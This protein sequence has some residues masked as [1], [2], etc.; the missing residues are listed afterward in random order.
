ME[1]VFHQRI[2]GTSKRLED[3][4]CYCKKNYLQETE[5]P[6]MEIEYTDGRTGETKTQIVPKTS[7][8]EAI[9]HDFSSLDFENDRELAEDSINALSYFASNGIEND[10]FI[11]IKPSKATK[12]S[13]QNCKEVW[14]L[15][16]FLVRV[17]ICH[18]GGAGHVGKVC[19]HAVEIQNKRKSLMISAC[20][21]LGWIVGLE[22]TTFR[23]TI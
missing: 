19:L 1:E 11:N 16:V 20:F 6:T 13:F 9:G 2:V 22:P 8:E 17:L 4:K 10:C 12:E 18:L 21:N 23:T 7:D 5:P 3:E 14:K 15:I